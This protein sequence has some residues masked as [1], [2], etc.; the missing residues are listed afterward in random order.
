VQWPSI[1]LF[2]SLEE[3]GDEGVYVLSSFLSRLN[4]FAIVG[5]GEAHADAVSILNSCEK[6]QI[7]ELC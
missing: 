5:I 4:R 6:P 7:K 2:K 3:N 1:E